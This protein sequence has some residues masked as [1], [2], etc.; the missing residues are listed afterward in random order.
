[1]WGCSEPTLAKRIEVQPE[2]FEDQSLTLGAKRLF[3]Q[4]IGLQ[5]FVAFFN[6]IEFTLDWRRLIDP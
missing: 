4:D 6:V 5:K 2:L 1:M 3:P